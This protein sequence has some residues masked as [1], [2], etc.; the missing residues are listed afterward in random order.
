M[1]DKKTD[2]KNQSGSGELDY[3]ANNPTG[4]TDENTGNVNPQGPTSGTENYDPAKK[5]S[6]QTTL[7]S[8]SAGSNPVDRGNDSPLD[9]GRN[10]QN[11]TSRSIPLDPR[12]LNA[13]GNLGTGPVS[14]NAGDVQD[15]SGN[16]DP[17]SSATRGYG[18]GDPGG[19]HSYRCSD[20]GNADCRWETSMASS[21][22][23]WADIE[24]HHRDVHGKPTLDEAS[25]GR[26]QDAI[27]VRRAA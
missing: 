12:D 9:D 26:I 8:D 3:G 2:R 11:W 22:E 17:G 21:N 7:G 4:G 20:A 6:Q 13:A 5:K 1:E 25:R 16:L 18:A 14:P 27:H 23:L 19:H 24:R 10:A 15:K